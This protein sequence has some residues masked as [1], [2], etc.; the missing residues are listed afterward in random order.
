MQKLKGLLYNEP[1]FL[2]FYLPKRRVGKANHHFT[3]SFNVFMNTSSPPITYLKDY[4]PSN[5]LIDEIL[6]R[7][8]L[9][10][11]YTCVQA[12]LS[13]RRNPAV[14]A[15][16]APLVL[17][18]EDMQLQAIRLSGDPL[19]T[20]QYQ[21][22]KTQLILSDV[23]DNFTLETEVEIK[24]Q[25]NL[26]LSGLYKTGANFCTQC[27]SHGFRRITYFLDRPDVLSRFT[28]LISAEKARYPILLANGNRT[29]QGEL[30]EG[31]HWVKWEDPT[32]KPSYLFA[33]VAGNLD[34]VKDI[35]VTCSGKK[36]QLFAY[37]ESGKRDQALY[38]VESLKEAMR[39][40][41]EKYGREYDLDIFMIVGVS[42][43][44]FGA[45][46][47]K[48]LNIF[49]DRY[50]LANPETATDE[51][52]I[53][54]KNVVAHEYFHNW[55]GNRVTVR[56][57]FQIT[58]KEGLTVF[59]DQ[60][61]TAEKTSTTIKR[62]QE[63]RAMRNVQ[64]LQ[65]AGPMAHSI[66]P[67][68]FIEINNFYTV[69]IYEKGAEVIR[70]IH[71]LLGEKTFRKAM[72]LYFSRHDGSPATTWDFVKAMED[73]S[74]LDLTQFWRW[75]IQSG[76]P[77]LDIKDKYD[78]QTQIYTL[79][80][81]Q[82]C[83]PT[84]HQPHKDPFHIPLVIGLLDKNGQELPLQFEGETT[85]A[86][87]KTRVL[88]VKNP[89]EVFRFTHIPT[90]PVPSLLRDFSAPVKLH[91]PFSDDDYLF[92]LS[93]DTNLYNR[94][95]AAQQLATRILLSCVACIQRD[96][97][98]I[99][100]S[101]FLEA[102]YQ[103]VQ[104]STLDQAV[105]AEI[106]TLPSMGYL[107]EQ[108]PIADVDTVHRAREWLKKQIAMV[109]KDTLLDYYQA[110]SV[111]VTYIVNAASVGKR[112][113]KNLALSYLVLL[114][115]DSTN[116]RQL[117]LTQFQRSNNMSD[118]MGA[119]LALNNVD[120]PERQ[121]ML[122][123]FYQRWHKDSLVVYKWFSCQ[124]QSTLSD[125]LKVVKSL[126]QHPAFDIKNPNCVRALIGA[127]CSGNPLN[128]HSK[129]GKGYTFLTDYVLTIDKLNPQLAARIVEPL[130]HWKKYDAQRQALM[131]VELE[132]IVNTQPLSNDVY[133]IVTRSL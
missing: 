13:I 35:F 92:L 114:D 12:T 101:Y 30:E 4:R 36:V 93:H 8:D 111:S 94:W 58:L 39:W 99:T 133:E 53:H 5:F 47:N 121:E 51:D 49:N 105:I 50:I 62:I 23:P 106:L 96:E 6:L 79:T 110:N 116:I 21:L 125:T 89:T 46:E 123:E 14:S 67:D 74:G 131:K 109:L 57:W 22:T 132:R 65:D 107:L 42:D 84:P 85:D 1:F 16:Q 113:F 129:T 64:F 54:I 88:S 103:I 43:F 72:D 45:M 90:K 86:G 120:C 100:P 117:C 128:F 44:N 71:T 9:Y 25:E 63:A 80:V 27:E 97:A 87:V 26:R 126:A 40:D 130:I 95:E 102:L 55:S 31:R 75:Y 7:I 19:Q 20:D 82:S 69:T 73:S 28:T 3:T 112:Q 15:G 119:M 32:L 33:L 98:C 56:D 41:E 10:E 38:A 118:T 61:F 59:R 104:D 91:Y 108:L 81:T 24:P 127:F 122:S 83:P 2:G 78:A 37:V 115:R 11:A 76:T 124:A 52:F 66:Y 70:M 68:S 17:D 60:Q 77:T 29:D 34:V 48:G 18:G